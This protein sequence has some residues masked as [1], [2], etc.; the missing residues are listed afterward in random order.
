[1]GHTGDMDVVRGEKQEEGFVFVRFDPFDRF[2]DELIGEVFIAPASRVSAGHETDTANAVMNGRIMAMTPVQFQSFTMGVSGG[3]VI[4][5]FVTNG[6]G[7]G[8]VEVE[9]MV[10]FDIDTGNTIICIWKQKAIVEADFQWAGFD[11]AVP[12]GSGWRAKAQVPFTDDG[13]G[14]AGLLEER[15]ES[16]SARLNQGGGV[17]AADAGS[18][19]AKGVFARHE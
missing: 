7:I 17:D 19:L 9:D 3:L 16:D 11:A 4:G 15:W 5:V 1:M 13:G 6:E 8:G 12:V 14:I 18:F 10:V 2:F